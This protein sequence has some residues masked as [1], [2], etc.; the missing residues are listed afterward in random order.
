MKFPIPQDWD[1][2]SWCEWAVCWPDSEQWRGLLRG[3]ITLPQRGRTWDERSGNILDVQAIGRE[4]TEQNIDLRGVLMACNDQGV[5]NALNA[6]AQAMTAIANAITAMAS[7]SG[8]GSVECGGCGGTNVNVQA[9]ISMPDG[10]TWPFYGSAPVPPLPPSGFPDGYPDLPTFEADRCAKATKMAD[11]WI[12]SLN[13]LGTTNWIA[14][15]LGAAAIVAALVGLIT[16][17]PAVIPLLLFALTANIGITAFLVELAN[18][19]EA[20]KAEV[21]CILYTSDS[22]DAIVQNMSQLLSSLILVINPPAGIG[23]GLATIALWLL[24]AD[25]LT[26]LF[27]SQAIGAYPSADCSGCVTPTECFDFEA[28]LSLLGWIVTDQ[29]GGSVELSVQATGMQVVTGSPSDTVHTVFSSPPVSYEIQAGDEFIILYTTDPVPYGRHLWLTLDSVRT[30]VASDGTIVD[31]LVCAP[32]DLT[33]YAG[34]VCT[35][36]EI[37]INRFGGG[38]WVI[39]RA[40]FNCPCA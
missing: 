1:G 13:N 12:T 39:R 23:R 9:H 31:H 26:Y 32:V 6:Q 11:D 15:V 30:L 33:P 38:T 29:T 28:E 5:A 19:L 17:P 36:I 4:I 25:T 24:N 35:D 40:G 21:I 16:V 20:N 2:E 18:E 34:Q 3:F 27:T 14:G 37:S 7:S 8:G 22:V 10:S